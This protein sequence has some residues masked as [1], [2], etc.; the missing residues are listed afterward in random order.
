M[1]WPEQ[2]YVRARKDLRNVHA[3]VVQCILCR[4]ALA[5]PSMLERPYV[6]D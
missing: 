3:R 5:Q 4:L 1:H 6:E 2:L